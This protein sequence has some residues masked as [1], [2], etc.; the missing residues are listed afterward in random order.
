[1]INTAKEGFY[2]SLELLCISLFKKYGNDFDSITKK[3]DEQTSHFNKY[4]TPILVI[5][6]NYISYKS[7]YEMKYLEYKNVDFLYNVLF[8]PIWSDEI[9]KAKENQ[10]KQNPKIKEI[11]KEFYEGFA[12]FTGSGGFF[13]FLGGNIKINVKKFRLHA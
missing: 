3:L 13:L 4:K 11:S 9:T 12:Y 7:F 6:G 10:Q 5:V 2:P 8:E 1:M